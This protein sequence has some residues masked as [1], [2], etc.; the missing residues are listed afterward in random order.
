M[1]IIKNCKLLIPFI[2]VLLLSCSCDKCPTDNGNNQYD[3]RNVSRNEGKS[4]VPSLTIDDIGN[5]HLVWMDSTSG[6][7]EILYSKKGTNGD[8]S[9]FVNISNTSVRSSSPKI[10][11]DPFNNLH[12]VWEEWGDDWVGILYSTRSNN[13]D[14]STP[15]TITNSGQ[16]PDMG[17]DGFGNVHVIWMGL[18]V[19]YRMRNTDGTWGSIENTQAPHRNPSMTANR[20]G[21]VHIV[22][23]G[24][25]YSDIYY[26]MKPCGGS[27]IEP[28]NLSDNPIYSCSPDIILDNNGNVYVAWLEMQTNQICFRVRSFEGVWTEID[29]VPEVGNPWKINIESDEEDLYFVWS[30]RIDHGYDDIYYKVRYSSGD[31]SDRM[32]VSETSNN[33]WVQSII[34]DAGGSLHIAWQEE[35]SDGWDIFYT[36]INIR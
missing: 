32:N 18:Q 15:S 14:W 7:Y 21:D 17:I 36:V 30:S 33:S 28:V 8:W 31:W 19:M 23:E 25:G 20:D 22:S 26:T 9:E 27:W 1:K 6:N 11:V 10:G 5:V 24:G 12:V 13:G 34:L 4:L 16:I 3:P 29:T 2:L 35:T